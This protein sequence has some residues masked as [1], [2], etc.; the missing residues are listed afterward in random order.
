MVEKSPFKNPE[1]KKSARI[2]Y[3]ENL[4]KWH[5]YSLELLASLGE[6]H[7]SA[8][9]NG[10]PDKIFKIATEHLLKIIEFD[11]VAFYLVDEP[12]ADFII[13][14]ISP[15]DTRQIIQKNVDHRIDDGSFAWAVNQNRPVVIKST[16]GNQNL[17][18]HVLS[19]KRRVRGM[20]AGLIKVAAPRLE[21]TIQ[22]TLSIIM[23]NTA[24]A[25][26][27]MA[28]YNLFQ[29]TNSHL[30]SKIRE[31]TTDLEDHMVKMK[32]EIAY[33]KLAE[34]SLWVARQEV[35]SSLKA[36]TDL[37]TQF[38]FELKTPINSI[39]DYGEMIRSEI[40][41]LGQAPLVESFENMQTTGRHLLKLIEGMQSLA[42]NNWQALGPQPQALKVSEVLEGI[43][44]TL[45]PMARK[46]NNVMVLKQGPDLGSMI[47]DE[48]RLRQILLNIIGNACKFTEN[49]K[50]IIETAIDNV[51]GE[52][53]ICFV[54]SD[55]GIGMDPEKARNLFRKGIQ[56][57]STPFDGTGMGLPFS[58]LLCAMLGGN[59]QVKSEVNKGSVFSVR[60][61]RD[62]QSFIA[63]Q[64]RNSVKPEFKTPPSTY[65]VLPGFIEE[66]DQSLKVS[67][68]AGEEVD[69]KLKK[70][71]I[72]VVDE[73]LDNSNILCQILKGQ[74]WSARPLGL[75][76]LT[77]EK[78]DSEIP[79]IIIIC[80]GVSGD[81]G[82]QLIAELGKLESMKSIPLLIFSARELSDDE[83]GMLEG[84]VQ[85]I[86]QKG[87]CTRQDLVDQIKILLR[88]K[89]LN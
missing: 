83:K 22:Y 78:L 37:L 85:G 34:E 9:Q 48:S 69:E 19:T 53:W 55:T 66:K 84:R 86:I 24:N 46:N 82:F 80:L 6:L 17:I 8:S 81:Q 64:R 27:S 25:L 1:Q 61:P 28:L 60:L 58:K 67:S 76:R 38:S 75:S 52:E 23:Q 13:K 35:E 63:R 3:L 16:E 51:A 88:N 74:G 79:D 62:I 30:E 7:H 56:S 65:Q 50:I 15:E 14:Y 32:E 68:P 72:C 12:D 77:L 26:E 49:G 39:L 59:I 20:F 45:I 89:S 54:I 21:E 43:L 87:N 5:L 71:E 42:Q 36:K 29:E 31:R 47:S 44:A 73:N 41:K 33:R 40:E 4:A 18:L 2:E 57:Q 10:G 11:A 70:K